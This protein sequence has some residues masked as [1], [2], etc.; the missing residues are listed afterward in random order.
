M[1]IEQFLQSI[2]GLSDHTRRAYN[3]TL[4]LLEEDL[5][6]EEPT[7]NDIQKFLNKYNA[8]SLHRHKAAI[9]A[10]WEFRFKGEEWPFNRRSFLAPRQRVPRYV[11]PKVVQKMIDLAE[12]PDDAMFV[13]TL[14]MMG[15]RIQEIRDFENDGIT[16]TGIIV[17]VKGGSTK[18]KIFTKDFRDVFVRYAKKKR[19]RIFPRSYTYYNNLIK[20]LGKEVDH[21]EISLH[22][23]RHSRAVDLLRK[24][25]KLSEVQQFLGHAN[26]N[27]TAIYLMITGGELAEQLEKVEGNHNQPGDIMDAVK[28]MLRNDPDMKKELRQLLREQGAK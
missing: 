4:C 14:F 16:D 11:N 1:K 21:P 27:T 5:T 8:S 9:K 3:I 13:R 20:R 6:G 24:G 22:M 10:Y 17:K 18:L 28:E 25:M 2:R 26:I 19:G 15:C 7:A 23:L 12:D